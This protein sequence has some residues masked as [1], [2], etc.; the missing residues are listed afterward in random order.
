MSVMS[1]RS[2]TTSLKR[3]NRPWNWWLK[4]DVPFGMVYLQGLFQFQGVWLL[5]QIDT[6]LSLLVLKNHMLLEAVWLFLLQPYWF[7]INVHISKNHHGNI[8][9]EHLSNWIILD[10]SFVNF[11]S[12]EVICSEFHT[13]KSLMVQWEKNPTETD[14]HSK[15]LCRNIIWVKGPEFGCGIYPS[16]WLVELNSLRESHKKH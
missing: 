9:H 7:F 10:T 12:F 13:F 4:D 3:K 6:L 14:I 11:M 5:L 8:E 15:D 16:S 2:M 1:W